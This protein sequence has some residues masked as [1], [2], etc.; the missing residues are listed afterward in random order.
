VPCCG[1]AAVLGIASASNCFKDILCLW[2][3]LVTNYLLDGMWPV[4]QPQ[5]FFLQCDRCTPSCT[6]LPAHLLWAVLH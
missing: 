1:M 5:C 3:V 2:M 4:L 6:I